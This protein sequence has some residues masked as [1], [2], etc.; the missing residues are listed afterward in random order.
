LSYEQSEPEELEIAR[1][2]LRYLER[3]PDAKDTLEGIAQWWILRDWTE[4]RVAEVERAVSL[5]VSKDFVVPCPREAQSPFYQLNR[6][7]EEEIQ[8][9]L[10]TK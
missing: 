7:K 6:Q 2:I 4:R 10:R 8:G 1:A 5:L 3:N 9:F